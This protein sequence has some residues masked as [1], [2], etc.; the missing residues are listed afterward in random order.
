MESDFPAIVA[1]IGDRPLRLVTPKQWRGVVK[2]KQIDRDSIITFEP[3]PGVAEQMRA[4]DCEL[5]SDIFLEVLGPEIEPAT[6]PPPP[7]PPP[8]ADEQVEAPASDRKGG[9]W[10][11]A[12]VASDQSDAKRSAPARVE[13][14]P[15][16]APPS[17]PA[18]EA[19][20]AQP[21][22]A[23][24]S[25]LWMIPAVLIGCLVI[26][27][28]INSF[29]DD[30]G[31]DFAGSDYSDVASDAE[32]AAEDAI[33]A[34]APSYL[35][36]LDRS[37][38]GDFGTIRATTLYREPGSG[39]VTS[40]RP[41]AKFFVEGT[42]EQY[43]Y[44]TDEAG[45][46]GFVAW[47]DVNG[48]PFDTREYELVFRNPTSETVY[49]AVTFKV[50]G[51]WRFELVTIRPG[52]QR[53]PLY[54]NGGVAQLD[55]LEAYYYRVRSSDRQRGVRPDTERTVIDPEADERVSKMTQ[56]VPEIQGNTAY[57]T[58]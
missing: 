33:A 48:N 25:G 51:E 45:N 21:A 23:G 43:A 5:L 36:N 53:Q 55:G 27:F 19:P 54:F 4:G 10:S 7:P 40:L 38:A 3:T 41:G 20:I 24:K 57:V 6:P 15:Q 13:T 9:P 22:P 49:L 14:E 50:R 29:I 11:E 12:Q 44:G 46:R 58:F 47:Q 32:A 56:I 37:S 35:D 39:F 1:E 30:D 16:P 18:P 26:M 2:R 34:T 42:V 31:D 28:M 8:P 17:P 52:T